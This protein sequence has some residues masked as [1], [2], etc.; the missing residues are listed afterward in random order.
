VK[1]GADINGVEKDG[2]PILNVRV[3]WNLVSVVKWMLE[4]DA[5]PNKTD[6]EGNAALHE[7]AARGAGENMLTVL[8]QHGADPSRRNRAGEKPVDVAARKKRK[9]F[10]GLLKELFVRFAKPPKKKAAK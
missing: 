8:L 4:R 10:E 2:Q 3:H 6:L 7:A 5:D 1:H 9:G